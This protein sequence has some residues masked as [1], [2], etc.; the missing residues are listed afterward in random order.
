MKKEN[1]EKA[2]ELNYDIE[3]YNNIINHCQKETSR[4]KVHIQSQGEIDLTIGYGCPSE[5]GQKFNDEIILMIVKSAKNK[6]QILEKEFA[7][8]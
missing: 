4:A 3:Y 6:K 1:F 2:K 8:L 7:R 5:T